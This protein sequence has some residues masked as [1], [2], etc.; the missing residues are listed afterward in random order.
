MNRDELTYRLAF[1]AVRGMGVD[2]ANKMLE[3]IPSEKDFF[4]AS[5]S[6]L[7]AAVG[8]KSRILDCDYRK[9]LLDKAAK[10]VDFVENNNIKV[11][12]FKDD[13]Y[14]ARF[15]QTA[16]DA[17]ILIYSFGKCNLN[18]KH[19]VSVVGTRHATVY[20]Q[21]FCD[22]LIGELKDKIQD[23]VVVSGLAYGI[24]ISAH[25]AALRHNV[26]TVAILANGLNRIY[27]TAHRSDAGDIVKQGGAIV[28]DYMSQDVIHKGNFVARNRIIAALADATIVVESAASGGALVTANLALSYN[29][30]VFA[31]PGRTSDEFSSGCNR[32][33]KSNQ[34]NLLTC[35][36]DIIDILRWD[37][38]ENN[39]P[40]HQPDLFPELT[41]VEKQVVE[42]IKMNGDVHTN[43]VAESLN[44]PVY[45]AMSTLMTLE[46]KGVINSLPGSRFAIA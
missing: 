15:T 6:D 10:E 41:D 16:P 42:F 45:K 44:M 19:V 34:A 17:P 3:V 40:K 1:G 35:A 25:R 8:R 36:D 20:G 39:A 23:L 18:S 30:D 24:D 7:V 13:D 11:T 26:P 31:V 14:P 38:I 33:I 29:R 12:Y 46:Y 21:K 32:L 5:T 37:T 28:T 9:K 4:V 43:T 22:K 27:P 2:L